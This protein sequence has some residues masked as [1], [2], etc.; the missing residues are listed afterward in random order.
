MSNLSDY[1]AQQVF[2]H[3]GWFQDD[4]KHADLSAT[5]DRAVFAFNVTE[6]ERHDAAGIRRGDSIARVLPAPKP[7]KAAKAVY[8]DTWWRGTM[9]AW[10]AAVAARNEAAG[11]DL[12]K[13]KRRNVQLAGSYEAQYEEARRE[14]QEWKER[15][16]KLHDGVAGMSRGLER[17]LA[18]N[19]L[20]KAQNRFNAFQTG[21][22]RPEFKDAS[23]YGAELK[24]HAAPVW[25]TR[26]GFTFD[27]KGATIKV[28]ASHPFKVPALCYWPGGELPKGFTIL[29]SDG[30]RPTFTGDY[31]DKGGFD[32][33]RGL[34][35]TW[36]DKFSETVDKYGNEKRVLVKKGDYGFR[37]AA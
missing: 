25:V 26:P 6:S 22:R 2:S 30:S 37:Y 4:E 9:T 20:E 13:I 1:V 32:E 31:F 14:L 29:T 18:R 35:A 7:Q 10:R 8:D 12:E 3:F 34:H 23:G 16:S 15:A 28:K 17:Q 36:H 27:Y 21:S 24:P 33:D 11:L 19:N 5:I